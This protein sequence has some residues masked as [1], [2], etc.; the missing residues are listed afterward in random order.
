MN[1]K[2]DSTMLEK[3]DNLS[4]I[5]FDMDPPRDFLVVGNNLVKRKPNVEPNVEPNLKRTK[6]GIGGRTKKRINRKKN[7]RKQKKRYTNRITL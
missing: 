6:F 7:S 1:T 4:D 3:Y 2:D 5:F